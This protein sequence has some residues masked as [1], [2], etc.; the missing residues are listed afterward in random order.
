MNSRSCVMVSLVE[1][2]TTAS[3]IQ[4]DFA[5]CKLLVLVLSLSKGSG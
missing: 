3:P 1:P 4:F 2:Y 5:H